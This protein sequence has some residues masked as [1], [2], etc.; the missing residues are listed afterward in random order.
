MR[1][2][3]KLGRLM[4]AKLS[5]RARGACR[6][7]RPCMSCEHVVCCLLFCAGGDAA[8]EDDDVGGGDDDVSTDATVRKKDKKHKKHKTK[9]KR[10]HGECVAFVASG[11]VEV[12]GCSGSVRFVLRVCRPSVSSCA[13]SCC[14]H[15][16]CVGSSARYS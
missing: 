6:L 4:A 3:D 2:K 5:Q 12:S 13:S 14:C 8:S 1:K 9:K 15:H 11:Y 10:K 7:A 16:C